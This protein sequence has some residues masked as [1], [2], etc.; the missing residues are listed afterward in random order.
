VT[1]NLTGLVWTKDTN[2]PG[3]SACSPTQFRTWQGALDYVKCLNNQNYLGHND[4][5]LPNRKELRSIF[6][7]SQQG[8]A[9]LPLGH[10]FTNVWAYFYWSSSTNAGET[11]KAWY[12]YMYGG[13]T[14]NYYNKDDTLYAWPVRA[15]QVWP[16]KTLTI[17]KTGKGSGSVTTD[18]G[19]IIWNGNVGTVTYHGG[20]SIILTATPDSG[21]T[22]AGWS[23]ACSG[24]GVCNITMNANTQVTADFSVK[25]DVNSDGAVNLT[26]AILAFQ[27][28]A[29]MTPAQAVN[30][31][32]DVD[33]DGK[34]GLA[35][36]IYILQKAVAIR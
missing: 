36:V 18:T 1:D 20:T 32:A 26:D 6:D 34:I 9:S 22:F 35:E 27:T 17:T 5:R 10:P 13:Y 30:K 3:P 28:I 24:R 12:F 21:L 23:G 2:P 4:W 16:I 8:S 7:Y 31:G 19:T 25:G 15:G 14:P 29:A 33:G 11:N